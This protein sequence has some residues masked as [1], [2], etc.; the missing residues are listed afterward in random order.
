MGWK[1]KGWKYAIKDEV[2]AM[3]MEN[4]MENWS[5]KWTQNLE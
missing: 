1:W 5:E 4:G 3:N 2:M